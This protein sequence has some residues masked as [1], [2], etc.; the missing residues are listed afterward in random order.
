MGPAFVNAIQTHGVPYPCRH[1][2]AVSIADNNSMLA[3]RFSG[4]S[5]ILSNYGAGGGGWINLLQ[6]A[7]ARMKRDC[8]TSWRPWWRLMGFK[9]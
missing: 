6:A 5:S 4:Y 1:G 3:I 8:G 7:A 2:D 9:R